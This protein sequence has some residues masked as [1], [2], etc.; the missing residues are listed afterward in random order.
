MRKR[1]LTRQPAKTQSPRLRRIGVAILTAMLATI[2]IV[3]CSNKQ[4][5]LSSNSTPSTTTQQVSVPPA[6]PPAPPTPPAKS[7]NAA[8]SAT[9]PTLELVLSAWQ[10]GDQTTAVRRFVEADWTARP[11]F[12]TNSILSLSETQFMAIPESSRSAKLEEILSQVSI[13]KGIARAVATAGKNAAASKDFD[14]ARKHFTSLKQCGEA[15]SGSDFTLLVQQVGKAMTKMADE[16]I[17]K[18]GQ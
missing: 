1:N 7:Q 5:D 8:G 6:P 10:Q 17:A 4:S 2:W 3:G 13:L 14:N 16:E 11:L 9:I 18:L 15:L 12:A